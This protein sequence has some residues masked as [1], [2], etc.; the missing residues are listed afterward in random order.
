MSD[1]YVHIVNALYKHSETRE[2]W[3]ID[4]LASV[5]NHSP[6]GTQARCQARSRVGRYMKALTGSGVVL[7]RKDKGQRAWKLATDGLS[8]D[9]E[10]SS[11]VMSDT[12]GLQQMKAMEQQYNQLVGAAPKP[13]IL[14]L[15]VWGALAHCTEYQTIEDI[16]RVVKKLNRDTQVTAG[17]KKNIREAAEILV[18]AGL[19]S[20]HGKGPNTA[21]YAC[22]R[23]I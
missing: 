5:V 21:S 11:L 19:A 4:A 20:K 16:T 15:L 17:Q 14:Y 10:K 6:D 12:A 3:D 22:I 7:Q 9:T 1:A 18:F 8:Y 13:E 2:W 23:Y